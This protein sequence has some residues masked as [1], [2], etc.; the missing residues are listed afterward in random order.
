MSSPLAGSGSFLL[1]EEERKFDSLNF[2]FGCW[3]VVVVAPG[4]GVACWWVE[5]EVEEEERMEL[6]SGS[7]LPCLPPSATER[8]RES[9][10]WDSY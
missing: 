9:H 8:E 5:E 2:F 6:C 1:L 3:S 4:V 7:I 10:N